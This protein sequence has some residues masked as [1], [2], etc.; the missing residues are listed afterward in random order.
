MEKLGSSTIWSKKRE[1]ILQKKKI[2]HQKMNDLM[3]KSFSYVDI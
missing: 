1:M 2:V 3:C